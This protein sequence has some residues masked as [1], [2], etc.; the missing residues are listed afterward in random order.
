MC[1]LE[2]WWGSPQKWRTISVAK[3]CEVLQRKA[4]KKWPGSRNWSLIAKSPSGSEEDLNV[5]HPLPWALRPS[6]NADL[7]ACWTLFDAVGKTESS[8]CPVTDI[9]SLVILL[10]L[11]EKT[12][13]QGNRKGSWIFRHRNE[14]PNH[15]K[16]AEP[17]SRDAGDH[18]SRWCT[19]YT[20]WVWCPA[21]LK[22]LV[23]LCM[24]CL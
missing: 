11:K 13:I 16:Q 5:W 17:G 7:E 20:S 10:S 19:G 23:A 3:E 4:E 2:G 21:Y 22:L 9:S 24:V 18:L 1:V 12:R 6:K 15:R 8:T 14:K